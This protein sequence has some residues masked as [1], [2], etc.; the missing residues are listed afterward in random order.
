[1]DEG[2]PRFV[3]LSS[4]S[5]MEGY[6]PNLVVTERWRPVPSTDTPVL[7]YHLGEYVCREFTRE[8]DITVVCLRLGKLEAQGDVSDPTA[9][10]IDD[11]VHAVERALITELRSS[12]TA[13]ARPGPSTRWSVFHIQSPVPN[14]RFMTATAERVLGYIPTF[15]GQVQR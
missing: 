10:H 9:L 12:Q 14:A 8:G 5:I 11:A 4:L 6:E 2:V 1:V 15:K 3:Y 13:R 7:C